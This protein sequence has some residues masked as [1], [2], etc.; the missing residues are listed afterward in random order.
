MATCGGLLRSPINVRSFTV[1]PL[2]KPDDASESGEEAVWAAR[3]L[4]Q[5]IFADCGTSP[6]IT[7]LSG[8]EGGDAPPTQDLIVQVC[9]LR[10]FILDAATFEA[11][12]RV[13]LFFAS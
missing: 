3:S 10:A 8:C 12:F 11:N 7:P 2:R 13:R 4:P 6:G 5:K 1:V 9:R